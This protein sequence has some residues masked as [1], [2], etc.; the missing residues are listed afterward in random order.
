MLNRTGEVGAAP[1]PGSV[2]QTPQ[3]DIRF[4]QI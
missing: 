3:T 4:L 1:V 2:Y